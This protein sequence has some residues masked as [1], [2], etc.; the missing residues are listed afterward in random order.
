MTSIEHLNPIKAPKEIVY[1]ALISQEGL[2]KVWTPKLSVRPEVGAINEFDFD[3]GYITK[4][5][6]LELSENE[7]VLWECVDS[8]EEW[9]GTK[10]SFE[11]IE[12]DGI[13]DVVL[14]HYDWRELT[15]FYRFC[16]YHWAMFLKRLKDYCEGK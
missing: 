14:K 13:T 5:K 1:Q 8:D 2:G 6:V 16:N 9:I 11:L 4:M 10:I 15:D 7:R 3:E 12:K